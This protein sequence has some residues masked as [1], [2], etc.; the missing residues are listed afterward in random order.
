MDESG[1]DYVVVGAGSA[2]CVV[3]AQLLRRTEARVLVLEAGIGRAESPTI[4]TPARWVENVG[5]EFDWQYR[6]EPAPHTA[7]RA[8]SLARGKVVGGSGSVNAMA[9]ARGHRRDYD[10]W[11]GLGNPGWGFDSL[12]PLFKRAE[13]WED[14]EDE[15][16]GAGG[17]IRVE[18]EHDL[19]PATTV[20][21]EAALNLGLP[22]LADHNV[23]EPLGAGPVAMNVRDGRRCSPWNGYLEPL[24]GHPR[25]TLRTEA[26]VHR[27][28]FSGSRCTG[29]SYDWRG[30][31][32]VATA[33]AEVLLAAGAV[34]T[35]RLLLVSGVGP[36]DELRHWGVDVVAGL[37]GVGRNLQDHPLLAGLSFEPA[38]P[39]PPVNADLSGT[40]AFWKSRPDLPAADL[41]VLAMQVPYLSPEIAAEYPP[42]PGAIGIVP[43]LVRPKSRGFLRLVSAG[44]ELEIQPNFLAEQADV[45]AAVAGVELGLEIADQPAYRKLVRS[46]IAPRGR[47]S[48]AELVRF[49]RTSCVSYFH[50]CGTCAMGPGEDA[51]VDA[52]LRVHGLDGLRVVDASVMPVITS[53][54]TQAP[55]VVI[56]ERA[57]DLLTDGR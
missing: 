35:P 38:E 9:W 16:H 30:Q 12:L 46:W 41:M 11:A 2:G 54:N 14:G 29:V 4:T 3:A 24:L 55:T 53:A 28:E 26:R 20:F 5:S 7:G 50:T 44:G 32:H 57:A 49:V 15:Y 36:A 56:A 52:R 42:P 43:A 47:L 17:P 22:Y 23:P 37:P 19:R 45:D 51:V 27:L 6:Y 18:R 34:D 10:T 21:V 25:L 31:R 13:D 40:A 8:M 1:F 48:R 39:Q 33:S